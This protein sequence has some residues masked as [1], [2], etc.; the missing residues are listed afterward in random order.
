[1][2][3]YDQ[4]ILVEIPITMMVIILESFQYRLFMLVN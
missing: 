2:W 3:I 1:M 4:F